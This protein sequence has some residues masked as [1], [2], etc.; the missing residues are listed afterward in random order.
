MHSQGQQI[1][2]PD[3]KHTAWPRWHVA[4]VA[5]LAAVSMWQLQS[6]AT[7]VKDGSGGEV[8]ELL[9]SVV[10]LP[11]L[12]LCWRLKALESCSP[13]QVDCSTS[14]SLPFCH[15][16]NFILAV[17]LSTFFFFSF[18]SSLLP[19]HSFP[20]LLPP[21]LLWVFITIISSTGSCC[22]HLSDDKRK[23]S[24]CVPPSLHPPFFFASFLSAVA[25]RRLSNTACGVETLRPMLWTNFWHQRRPVMG[26]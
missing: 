6:T 17:R 10:S 7:F 16:C 24:R 5:A 11:F 2:F 4:R 8:T 9:L 23:D 14:D 22:F 25:D 15:G 26:D 20:E 18:I 12:P 21:Q 1:S 19:F 3:I 13:Q